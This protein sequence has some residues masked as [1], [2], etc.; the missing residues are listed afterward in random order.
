[1]FPFLH[2]TNIYPEWPIGA[3]DHVSKDVSFEV[4]E[5]LLNLGLYASVGRALE[6]CTRSNGVSAC[7]SAV[8]SHPPR[9]DTTQALAK[10]SWGAVRKANIAGFRTLRSYF[11]VTD[12]HEAAG[13]ASRNVHGKL[14]CDRTNSLYE[15]ISCPVKYYKVTP[16]AYNKSCATIGLSCKEGNDCYCSPCIKAFEVSVFET[17]NGTSIS[18]ISGI[19]KG[20]QDM[21]NSG[22]SKM[23]ICGTIE[24][25]RQVTFSAIDNK[26]RPGANVS[27]VVHV[28][29]TTLELSVTNLENENF[30]YSFNFTQNTIGVAVMEIF[31]D[32]EQIPES[33]LRVE[34]IARNCDKDF[35]GRNMAPDPFGTCVCGN[36]M[37]EMGSK[38]VR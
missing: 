15:S 29:E 3:L 31:V 20:T 4:Q 21:K 1:M 7:Q 8:M 17:G 35:P 23:S 38:C 9:C 5:A 2:S 11:G 18:G 37:L 10:F 25:T 14:V 30:T 16:S 6:D 13:F 22:C 12:M 19:S 36:G 28:G 32:G 24:Q 26:Q 27:A 33:P 34:I